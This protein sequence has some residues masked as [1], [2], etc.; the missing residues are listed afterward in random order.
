VVTFQLRDV[1]PQEVRLLVIGSVAFQGGL[2]KLTSE[3][4]LNIFNGGVIAKHN[5]ECVW[6]DGRFIRAEE[7][8]RTLS[9][10]FPDTK[11]LP[12]STLLITSVAAMYDCRAAAD[13]RGDGTGREQVLAKRTGKRS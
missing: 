4:E 3:A 11:P 8:P 5:V 7:N 1:L 13:T 2:I 12:R 6:P 10:T 9:R